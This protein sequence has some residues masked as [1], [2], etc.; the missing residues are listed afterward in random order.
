MHIQYDISSPP[1]LG[2][3]WEERQE[4][5]D[6]G[7][8]SA[9]LR[10]IALAKEQPALAAAALRD[11]LPVL[12]FR[13]GLE[14]AIKVKNKVGALH[15]IAMWQGLRGNNLSIDLTK[16]LQKTCSLT[17]VTVTFTGDTKRL[18]ASESTATGELT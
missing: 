8:I 2:E 9:W 16:E 13:G 6:R 17:K 3:S 5:P 10:G 18:L 4:G 1:T 12:P 7:L 14:R 15:Y 11:E